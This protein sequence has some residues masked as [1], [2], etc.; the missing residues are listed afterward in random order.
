MTDYTRLWLRVCC[1]VYFSL[2]LNFKDM[3]W[4]NLIFFLNKNV[5]APMCY[6][7]EFLDLFDM[8]MSQSFTYLIYPMPGD[9]KIT[10]F[11]LFKHRTIRKKINLMKPVTK[12]CNLTCII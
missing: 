12:Y 3:D 2:A 8:S 4:P 1:L 6:K 11:S 9:S 5:I 10:S 7:L